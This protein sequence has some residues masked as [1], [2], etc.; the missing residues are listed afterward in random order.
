MKTI[1]CLGLALATGLL[2]PAPSSAGTSA[3]TVITIPDMDCPECAKEV[4][5]VLGKVPGVAKVDTNPKARTVTVRPRADAT[6]S[7]R[8]LWEAVERAGYEP[9]RLQGPSGTFASKPKK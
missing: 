2:M 8:A 4:A 5:G 7:P 6:P 1:V 9:Q 3:P